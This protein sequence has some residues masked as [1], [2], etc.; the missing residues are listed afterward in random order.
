LLAGRPPSTGERTRDGLDI[1]ESPALFHLLFSALSALFPSLLS[2]TLSMCW[3]ANEHLAWR[4]AN[5]S[6]ELVH[7]VVAARLGLETRRQV[8]GM[9]RAYVASSMRLGTAAASFMAADGYLLG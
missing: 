5:G 3:P 4:V 6:S 1:H 2:A 9:Q 8:A 7:L